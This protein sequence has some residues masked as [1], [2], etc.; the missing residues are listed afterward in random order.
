MSKSAKGTTANADPSL[1]GGLWVKKKTKPKPKSTDFYEKSS[2]L[3]SLVDFLA[4]AK[5]MG[6][7]PAVGKE[8][9]LMFMLW[10]L[11]PE[12]ALTSAWTAD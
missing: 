5:R 12:G 7:F 8:I 1:W 6:Q 2:H 11:Q 4:I 10:S 9:R 3:S